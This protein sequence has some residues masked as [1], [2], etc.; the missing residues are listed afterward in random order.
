MDW[1]QLAQNSVEWR[2]FVNTVMSS[3]KREISEQL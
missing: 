2:A 1:V 3:T